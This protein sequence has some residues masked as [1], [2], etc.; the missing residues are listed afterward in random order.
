MDPISKNSFFD[1]KQEVKEQ[2]LNVLIMK[3]LLVYMKENPEHSFM[4]VL[5]KTGLFAEEADLEE[6][7]YTTL[8][9]MRQKD[10]SKEEK[11]YDSYP[12]D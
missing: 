1:F 6:G 5:V 4:R 3:S 11:I 10:I 7:S 12:S 8:R 2:R 9:R